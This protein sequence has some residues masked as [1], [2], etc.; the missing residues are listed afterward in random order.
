VE[1]KSLREEKLINRGKARG[2]ERERGERHIGWR[3]I[4]VNQHKIFH[5]SQ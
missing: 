4:S 1:T 3:E 2:R 5:S